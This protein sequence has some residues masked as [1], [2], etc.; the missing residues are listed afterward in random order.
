MLSHAAKS[1]AL[2][3]FVLAIATAAQR[4]EHSEPAG[5]LMGGR[6]PASLSGVVAKKAFV[7]GEHG[8]KGP[9]HT[10]K[11]KGTT[12]VQIALSSAKPEK[13]GDIFVLT[14]T[15]SVSANAEAVEFQWSLP[16]NAE[17]VS[18]D[19]Q[20]SFQNLNAG[21]VKS[22]TVTVKAGSD[23]NEQIHL[24]VKTVNGELNEAVS[25]QYNSQIQDELDAAN[26]EQRVF[27]E[28]QSELDGGK[29]ARVMH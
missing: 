20:A 15:I 13:A 10:E 25:A 22:I 8:S 11:L 24:L 14:A 9:R 23:H 21:D 5:Q 2:F 18:G 6:G 29:K 19:S 12:D 4:A 1:I 27:V 16:K 7:F 3:A 17:L 26:A 28:S